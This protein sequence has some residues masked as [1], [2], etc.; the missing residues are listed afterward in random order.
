[1]SRAVIK[2]IEYRARKSLSL[3]T[4]YITYFCV[5]ELLRLIQM[6]TYNRMRAKESANH[7]SEIVNAT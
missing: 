7:R 4:V 5:N 1:M 3:E 2:R 6:K